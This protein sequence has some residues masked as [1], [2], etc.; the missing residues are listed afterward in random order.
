MFEKEPENE[1]LKL[2]VDPHVHSEDSFDGKE[3]VELIIEQA[4][5][6]DIDVI[7]ITDHNKIDNSLKGCELAEDIEDLMVI[8]GIEISTRHGHLL[9]IGIDKRIPSGLPI[10]ETVRRIREE[11]GVA[12]IPHPF[13]KSRHG[14]RKKNIDE[15]DAIETLNA[16]FF[17]GIQNKRA[18]K[19]AEKHGYTKI[20]ASDA[21][22]LGTIGK[23]YTEITFEDKKSLSEVEIQEVLETIN[24]GGTKITGKRAA[25]HK[26]IYHYVKAFFRK[27]AYILK[28]ILKTFLKPFKSTFNFLNK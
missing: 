10:N 7:V 20:G 25:M 18:R 22:S 16:W 23:C 14:V 4:A 5:D 1:V 28:K 26:H 12:I 17:T 8:P 24:N 2:K 27:T 21:H 9:G 6:I 15:C 13:Q 3:P 11:G 19:F